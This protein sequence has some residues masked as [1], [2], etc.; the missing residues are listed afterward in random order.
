MWKR[1]PFLLLPFVLMAQVEIERESMLF[2]AES[3]AQKYHFEVAKL[4]PPPLSPQPQLCLNTASIWFSIDLAE[5][6]E[7]AFDSLNNGIFWELLRE[8]GVQG[9]YLKGLKKGGK[10]RTGI[11]LDPK[12][13]A[14][15]NDVALWLQKKKVALIGD[16]LGSCTG[17]SADFWLA[18][19]NFNNYAA[20]YH[21]IEIEKQD[22]NTLPCVGSS[23]FTANVPWLTLQELHKKGY[24]PE[25]FSPYVKKS[26]WDATAPVKC[27]DGKVRRWI[28]LKEGEADP[29]IDWLNPS[30]AGSRIAAADMLDSIFNLGQKIAKLDDSIH[31]SAKET[32]ALWTR[33]LGGTSVLETQGGLQDWKKAPTDMI[34]DTLTRPAL[35]HALIAEDAEA[36]KMMYR[37]FLDEG[38]GTQRLV[39]ALQPF[40]EFTCDWAIL[41]ANP[42]KRFKYYEEIFTGEALR[43]RLLKEDAFRL[44]GAGPV[45]WPSA[46]LAALGEPDYE[47]K[48]DESA[49]AHLLLA[50]FYAMQPG[51]FSF[52]LSDLLG[53]VEHQ[54]VDL[55]NPNEQ[56]LYGSLPS[57]MKNSLSFAMQLKKILS[58]RTDSGI[59]FGELLAVPQTRQKGLL[60]LIHRLQGGLVQLLAV[61]FGRTPVTQT[62]EIPSIKQTTAIDLMTGL[63]EKKPLDSPTIRLDLLPLTGKAILFQA[64]YFGNSA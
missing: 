30:F 16:S 51:V 37:L 49:R 59:E 3:I 29:A 41:L 17:L 8:I 39:H 24:V 25:Q 33:K 12:W 45:T 43:M 48:R 32:Q 40:D 56:S 1:L 46:C 58:V 36:L 15:W 53:M 61:N 14:D 27:I 22:W 2:Q 57:Q 35:L 34:S 6:Q 60:I 28:Y 50:F 23:D 4:E 10:S 64:K 31:F 47:K 62:L 9:V 52:S 11:S 21:L 20:L 54:T 42:K 63:A 44:R 19:K 13:G 18:L 5:L 55:M 7:P 26:S 38:I